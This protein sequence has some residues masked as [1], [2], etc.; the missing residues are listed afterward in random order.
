MKLKFNN[1]GI[2]VFNIKDI[3][4]MEWYRV[5]W[6][7]AKWGNLTKAAQELHITQPSVSYTIKQMEEAL[8]VKLFDRL[9]KGVRL[10]SEGSALL[11]YVEKSF[12]LLQTGEEKIQSLKNLTSGELRIGASGPIIKHVLLSYLDEF[13]ASYPEVRI[14]LYQGKTSHIVKRLKDGHIDFGLIHMPVNDK[15]IEVKPLLNIQDCFVVGKSYCDLSIHPISTEQLIEIPLLLLSQESSTRQFVEQWLSAQGLKV[16]VDIEL[17]SLEMLV[18]LAERGYGAAFVTRPFVM[19]ELKAGTL[20]ELKQ[21]IAI[22]SR[23]IGLA[24]QRDISLPLI[25]DRFINGLTSLLDFPT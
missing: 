18:E 19:D 16:E 22:P 20:F 5:F 7:T 4:S 14:R 25:A 1:I 13:H 3:L 15:S 9:S 12:T 17:S 8:G 10:T 2:E 11:E 23:T 6:H 24:I 21:V